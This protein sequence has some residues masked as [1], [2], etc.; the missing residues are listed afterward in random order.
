MHNE[1]TADAL[2][3]Q[4]NI[5]V[6]KVSVGPGSA[7]QVTNHILMSSPNQKSQPPLFLDFFFS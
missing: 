2:K 1:R 3:T 5:P 7:P 4:S 6:L